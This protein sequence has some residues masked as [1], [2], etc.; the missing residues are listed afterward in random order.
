VI[1]YRNANFDCNGQG[2]G[3]GWTLRSTTGWQN[4]PAGINDAV[5]SVRVPPGW[6]VTFYEHTDRGGGWACR[7]ADAPDFTGDTFSNG[8]PLNDNVSSFYVSDMPCAFAADSASALLALSEA[9]A[10]WGDYDSDGDLDLALV[11]YTGT[12]R[13][14]RLYRNDAG[15]LHEV[16]AVFIGLF[17]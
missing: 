15:V 4:L 16:S 3:I 12:S 10:A 14:T 17:H 13:A 11:G 2:E 6:S 1:V 8:V 5:S 7:Q 9:K